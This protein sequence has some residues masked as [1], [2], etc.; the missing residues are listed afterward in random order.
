MIILV[1]NTTPDVLQVTCGTGV[2][3]VECHCSW[4]EDNSGAMTPGNMNTTINGSTS[5]T[6]IHT[7]VSTGQQMNIKT[8]TVRNV[9]ATNTLI[10]ISHTING[11]TPVVML[12]ATLLPNYTIQYFDGGTFGILDNNG[13]Q[14]V[15]SAGTTLS[16]IAGAA[17]NSQLPNGLS[18][19]NTSS[20][21]QVT[22]AGTNYYIAGS[23]LNLPATLINGIQ[24]GTTF[25][26]KVAMTKTAA[27]TVAFDILIFMG[28]NGTVSDT[29]EVTQ[30]VGVQTAAVDNMVVDV[31]VT[32][33]STTAFYWSIVTTNKAVSGTGF[34]PAIGAAMFSGTVTGLTT[35]TASLIFGLGFQSNTGTPTVVVPFVTAQAFNLD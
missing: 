30:S 8:L 35:T 33:T 34:G 5:P 25:V 4:I 15:N 22:V 18:N 9:S 13:A 10:T 7:P 17:L 12:T 20:Q 23:N 29:A 19:R 32:F 24:A 3:S 16:K 31:M 14:L 26:W 28:T 1:G 6:T 27:G 11:G 21:S 2:T